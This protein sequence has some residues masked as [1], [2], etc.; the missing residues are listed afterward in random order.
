MGFLFLWTER[1]GF[2]MSRTEGARLSSETA[3]TTC[4]ARHGNVIPPKFDQENKT[5]TLSAG[6]Q[7]IPG[8]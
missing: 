1:A 6:K 7:T 2:S 3:T 4:R 5:K 8:G